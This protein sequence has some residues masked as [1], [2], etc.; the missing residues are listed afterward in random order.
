MPLRAR[1]L[2]FFGLAHLAYLGLVVSVPLLGVAWVALALTQSGSRGLKATGCLLLLPVPMGWYA[3][4]VEPYW[5][6]V[7]ELS[8]AIDPERSGDDEVRIAVLA[9]LQ[10]NDPWSSRARDHRPTTGL[11]AR[12]HGPPG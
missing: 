6:R 1:G 3:S 7:D 12:P 8:V 11:E 9:D 4:H 10:T 5:L 2:G